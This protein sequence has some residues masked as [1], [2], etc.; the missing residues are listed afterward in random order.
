MYYERPMFGSPWNFSAQHSGGRDDAV[1]YASKYFIAPF[2]SAGNTIQ[3]TCPRVQPDHT[4][5]T[6][7]ERLAQRS[8]GQPTRSTAQRLACCNLARV[9]CVSGEQSL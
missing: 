6:W 5:P 9:K 3:V 8:R 4:L 1:A 2:L 7:S